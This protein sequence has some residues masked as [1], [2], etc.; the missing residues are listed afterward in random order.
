M[1]LEE[2]HNS[3]FCLSASQRQE[4][5]LQLA[6]CWPSSFPV[7]HSRLCRVLF[8]SPALM[9]LWPIGEQI[10]L[11][12]SVKAHPTPPPTHSPTHRK[13]LLC[14]Y[15]GWMRFGLCYPRAPRETARGSATAPGKQWTCK[16]GGQE[17]NY[18]TRQQWP[19]S[20]TLSSR[21]KHHERHLQS[22]LIR[23]SGF[24]C[25]PQRGR[26]VLGT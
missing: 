5:Q 25:P 8:S 4:S 18:P 12:K 15:W 24:L 1:L 3:E 13:L 10:P 22:D 9:F 19:V 11:A 16:A 6:F 21:V 26:R 7:A 17:R 2:A 14:H 23:K 20:P